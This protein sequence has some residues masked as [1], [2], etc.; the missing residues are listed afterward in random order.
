MGTF[1]ENKTARCANGSLLERGGVLWRTILAGQGMLCLIDQC[2]VSAANFLT[3]VIIARTCLK[4]ELGLYMLGL[5][6]ILFMTDSQTSLIATPYMI[7]APRL[8]DRT[9]ALYSGSTLMHQLA[10]CMLAMLGL[11]GGAIA[12]THGI[13]PHTMAPVLWT[14]VVIVP[15][16]MLREYVR[17][18]CFA[19]LK[20]TSV[21]LFDAYIALGQ[22]CG[23]LLLSHSRFLS[24]RSAYLV[25]GLA[26]GLAVTA[27]LSSNR[28]SFTVRTGELIGDLKRNWHCGK[29]I[30]ASG[31]V[32]AASMYLYPWFLA[33]FHGTA[34]AGVWAACLGVVAFG[35]PALM[36][37][38]NFLGPKIAHV[39][40]AQGTVVLRR[41]VLKASAAYSVPMLLFSAA[42]VFWGDRLVVLLYGH[43]YAGNGV[44]V[45][46]LGLNLFVCAAA[47]SFSRALFAIE[48]ADLDFLV[49]F[50]ALIVMLTLGL[51]L[52]RSVG[53]A[54][55]AFGVLIANVAASAARVVTF[56][57]LARS[58]V[59][60]QAA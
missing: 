26:A 1:V 57:M 16:L 13:G 60:K 30:F 33:A 47:F 40:A 46:V 53:V 55:A 32:W 48:R 51:W 9:H 28:T 58:E 42:I 4:E 14:L 21:L 59:T 17:R 38:Q 25:I 12:V 56:G 37:I 15:I 24:A 10:L 22:V 35:N 44:V 29:W 7:Y 18:I 6:L 27:W 8:K 34:S 11:L 31:L 54:G 43:Q 39:Y 2:I 50:V 36:G 5:S 3:G 23:L 49:N 19:C 41:F 20:L 52:V 45:T